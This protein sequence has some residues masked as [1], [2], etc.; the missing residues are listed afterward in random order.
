MSR[1]VFDSGEARQCTVC[2]GSASETEAD[3][4][5]G[6]NLATGSLNMLTPI[7]ENDGG[8]CDMITARVASASEEMGSTMAMF[9]SIAVDAGRCLT[10]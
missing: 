2:L 4:I 1:A 7:N 5:V 10:H 3:S 9:I 8:R 6:C